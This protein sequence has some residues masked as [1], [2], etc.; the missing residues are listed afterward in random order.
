[1][2]GYDNYFPYSIYLTIPMV[3][4]P[5]QLFPKEYISHYSYGCITTQ[6]S[7]TYPPRPDSMKSFISAKR[8][9]FFLAKFCTSTTMSLKV[10]CHILSLDY[11]LSD[12]MYKWYLANS[13]NDY[14]CHFKTKHVDFGNV[15]V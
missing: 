6:P 7:P 8:C 2:N 12:V 11:C 3:L 9:I 1:M 13:Y 5:P 14:R 15:Y 10:F 4:L